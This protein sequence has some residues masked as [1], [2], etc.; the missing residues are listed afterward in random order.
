MQETLQAWQAELSRL[1]LA[2]AVRDLV[3]FKVLAES[4]HIL[5]LGLI[6]SAAGILCARTAGFGKQYQPIAAADRRVS[7]WIC[8][9]MLVAFVS[10]FV[11]LIGAG[12][13]GLTNPLFLIK[14]MLMVGALSLT[15]ILLLTVQAKP[16]FRELGR[17]QR[18]AVRFVALFCFLLW[19]ATALA[20]RWLAY[21]FVIFPSTR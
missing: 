15:A 2:D 12:R 10:G 20:G 7:P 17:G 9:A 11:L 5:S 19:I 14:M 8:S 21:A 4:T 6:L 13:R 16:E 18:I 3:W 1:P